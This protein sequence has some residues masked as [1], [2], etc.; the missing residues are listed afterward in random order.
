M[1]SLM[2]N[3][4][5]W[6]FGCTEEVWVGSSVSEV[7][8]AFV[9]S[10]VTHVGDE[11]PSSWLGSEPTSS[12]LSECGCLRRIN[13][14]SRLRISSPYSSRALQT[15]QFGLWILRRDNR[16]HLRFTANSQKSRH[17]PHG[18]CT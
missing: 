18:C 4:I 16:R 15:S 14:S 7:L 12:W 6:G 1:V 3:P 2:G 11:P 9:A 13:S 8:A 17:S 5:C 10:Q